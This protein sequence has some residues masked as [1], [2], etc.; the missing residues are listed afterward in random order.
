MTS[1]WRK[2]LILHAKTPKFAPA[3]VA[4]IMTNFWRKTLILHAKTPKFAPARDNEL[5]LWGLGSTSEG[6]LPRIITQFVGDDELWCAGTINIQEKKKNS[7]FVKICD[8]LMS[9]WATEKPD[10]LADAI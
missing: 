5:K 1:F 10:N 6:H 7:L 9:R 8:S 2:T 4:Q 3:R